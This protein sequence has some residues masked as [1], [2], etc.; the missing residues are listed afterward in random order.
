MVV[1]DAA[2]PFECVDTLSD[3]RSLLPSRLILDKR[4]NSDLQCI[5]LF[6]LFIHA[7]MTLNIVSKYDDQ[8]KWDLFSENFTLIF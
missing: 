5:L 2:R 1:V 6:S 4:T 3:V 8:F 7:M